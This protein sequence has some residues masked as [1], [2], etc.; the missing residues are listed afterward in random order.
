MGIIVK[1][2]DK[3]SPPELFER[4]SELDRLCVGAEGW[5]AGS[6]R[7]E[8]EKENGVVLYA[9]DEQ[10][11]RIAALLS[12]YHAVGEGDITSVAAAFEYRRMGLATRLIERFAELLPEDA[13]NIF[14]EVRESNTAA[15]ALYEKCGFTRLSLRKNFYA[16]PDENAVVMVRSQ[17]HN[18]GKIC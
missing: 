17:A 16:D 15:A 18:G 3:N 9:E 6:F 10:S 4:L 7:S 1:R 2:A 8:A 13:E 12:G 14:L 5:S 11:G